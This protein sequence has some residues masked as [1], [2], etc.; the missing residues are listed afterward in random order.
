[1]ILIEWSG[2]FCFSEGM[3]SKVDSVS[4]RQVMGCFATGIAVATGR[5][6]ELGA[7]GLTINSLTSL[8]LD[9]PLLLFC[10]DKG[11]HLHKA[12]CHGKFFAVNI[13]AEGQENISRHF[14][15]R[16]H[17]AAPKNMWDRPKKNCPTLRGT[18]G[19]ALCRRYALHGGGDHTILVGEVIDLHKRVGVKEPLLYFHG[20]YREMAVVKAL[21]GKVTSGS[22]K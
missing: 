18:L 21:L 8:S 12:F 13:L 3:K 16:H 7:F 10:L 2:E 19:W 22:R 11:A 1:M 4:F 14:A 5:N 9:P 20:R 6:A 15:D 17:H